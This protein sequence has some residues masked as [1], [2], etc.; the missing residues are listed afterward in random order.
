MAE[1]GI[2]VNCRVYKNMSHGF[3]GMDKILARGEDAVVDSIAILK[4]F[5]EEKSE[6]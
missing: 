5:L 6:L 3:L 2:D 4:E 1:A